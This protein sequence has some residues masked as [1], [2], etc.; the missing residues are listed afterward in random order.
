MTNNWIADIAAGLGGGAFDKMM[1]Q[2]TGS[3]T[4]NLLDQYRSAPDFGA[5]TGLPTSPTMGMLDTYRLSEAFQAMETIRNTGLLGTKFSELQSSIDS[6]HKGLFAEPSWDRLQDEMSGIR[7]KLIAATTGGLLGGETKTAYSD[8]LSLAS[9]SSGIRDT[10]TQMAGKLSFRIDPALQSMSDQLALSAR[11]NQWA[12]VLADTSEPRFAGLYSGQLEAARINE[13]RDAALGFSHS[14]GASAHLRLSLGLDG[15]FLGEFEATRLKL[16]AFAGA[17][18][19]HGFV[20]PSALSAYQNLFGDWRTRSDLPQRFWRDPQMRRRMYEDADV[21]PGLVQAELS[22]A[23][24]V[25]VE[26]GLAAGLRSPS[27]AVAIISVG[28]VSMSIRSSDT[29]MDAYQVLGAFEE[30]LRDF[31]SRKLAQKFGQK[32][33]KQRVHGSLG[34]KAI[35]IREAA[36]R[37]GEGQVPLI[38][39]L[40]LGDLNA[41]ILAGNNWSEVFESV[42]INRE[43]LSHDMQKLIAARRPT[44]HYRKLDGVRLVE[45]IC[46]IERLTSQMNG[47]GAW[48]QA[49]DDDE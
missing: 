23:L 43:E 17:G 42:F 27:G 21:D 14:F 2:I 49:L 5:L 28:R 15:G 37:R 13:I 45:A 4:Q 6:A 44:A 26:S 38:N 33:F 19:V 39:Y 9:A 36:L 24:D 7:E 47:D 46:V 20:A 16:S 11:T 31:I 29:R 40:D 32:W 30:E 22:M 8:F 12:S 3:P 41:I 10:F 18:D 48:L 25:V 1:Q 35:E 34:K